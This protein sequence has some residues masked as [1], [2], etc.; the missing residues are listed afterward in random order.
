MTRLLLSALTSGGCR[1]S[2]VG[3]D[4]LLADIGSLAAAVDV[5][6]AARA[7]H[8]FRLED[9][10]GRQRAWRRAADG[11]RTFHAFHGS[12]FEN[13]HSI[14]SLGLHQHLNKVPIALQ[15]GLSE[16]N[17]EK[18]SRTRHSETTGW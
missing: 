15:T 16:L 18:R 4:E 12:R 17:E 13:F 9:S 8:Y 10:D 3:R 1:L 11:R 14:L 7:A 2:S 6:G 5:D